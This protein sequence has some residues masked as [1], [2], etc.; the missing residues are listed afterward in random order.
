MPVSFLHE[1][2]LWLVRDRPAFVAELL[3]QLLDVHVP[4]FVEARLT[5]ATL[6]EIVP[7]EYHADAVVLLV[8]DKPVFG[9]IVEAQLHQDGRKLYTW[10]LYGVAARARH[11]CPFE[12]VVV[13]PDPRVASWASQP[14]HLG[15]GVFQPKVI[16]PEKIPKVT[17]PTQ[18]VRDPQLAVLS[19]AAHGKGDVNTAVQI[20]LAASESLRA[21]SDEDQRML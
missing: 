5:E 21:L 19:V 12:V 18:A 17:D 2:L 7:I 8:E 6:N 20:A 1:G 13:A 9:V 4:P 3:T 16:G 11:E 10:P 14:I 15:G